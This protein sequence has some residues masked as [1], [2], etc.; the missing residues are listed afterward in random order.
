[1]TLRSQ[2]EFVLSRAHVE[3]AIALYDPQE[4]RS[5]AYVYGQ[6][7]GIASRAETAAVLWH[8]GYPDESLQRVE[9]ALLLAEELAHPL[10]LVYALSWLGVVHQFRGEGQKALARFEAV[11]ALSTEQGFPDWVAMATVWRGWTLTRLGQVEK[12][13]QQ[14]R[15]GSATYL[16]LGVELFQPWYMAMLAE[17]YGKREQ[18]EEGLTVIAEALELVAKL[19]EYEHESELYRL[20]GQLTLQANG[21]D[22]AAAWGS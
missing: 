2:G 5:H 21:L 8:L 15:Q 18:V 10:S 1:M 4:H 20:K 7:P 9:E 19:G 12:G 22:R 14:I 3:Q 16:S 11:I 6:D 17:A 13:L